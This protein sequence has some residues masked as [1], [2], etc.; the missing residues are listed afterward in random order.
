MSALSVTEYAV[1]GILAEK[2]NHGFALAKALDTDS[3]VGRI[4]TVRRPLVYRALDRLV[5]A[6][7]AEAIATQ[8]S[9]AGPR[10]V[11]HRA[12]AGGRTCLNGWLTEPVQHIRD[13]RVEFLL[14]VTIIRR[15]GL[16]PAGL[17]AD[18]RSALVSTLIAL[19]EP[20]TD[21]EDHV[22]LWRRHIAAAAGAYLED[23]DSRFGVG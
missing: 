11:I 4:F 10:R 7:H 8:A 16:S 6:G 22:E 19:D 13:M 23:L 18:Q 9:D 1:L 17:I 14:K 3:D 20:A 12:T 5:D 15:A 2:P 21:P